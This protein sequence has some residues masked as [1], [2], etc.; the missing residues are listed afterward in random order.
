L[1]A[2][3]AG[4]YD[5]HLGA[6]T[7]GVA[8]ACGGPKDAEL[9]ALPAEIARLQ[10]WLTASGLKRMLGREWRDLAYAREQIEVCRGVLAVGK[11]TQGAAETA[12]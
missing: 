6:L 8:K 11:S 12:R 10:Q 5:R 4:E 2:G 1:A 7:D 9:A 3:K